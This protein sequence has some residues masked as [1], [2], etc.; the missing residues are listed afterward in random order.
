MRGCGERYLNNT[1]AEVWPEVPY[2]EGEFLYN[3]YYGL[4]HKCE[5]RDEVWK[6]SC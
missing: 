4:Y 5:M 3:Q 6:V 2:K 1:V